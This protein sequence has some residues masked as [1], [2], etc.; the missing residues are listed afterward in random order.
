MWVKVGNVAPADPSELTF[1]VADPRTTYVPAFDGADANKVGHYL[2][3]WES[4]RGEHRR[5]SEAA[6][7]TIGS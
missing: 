1:L 2:L 5:T 4:T 3:C 6:S 7:T